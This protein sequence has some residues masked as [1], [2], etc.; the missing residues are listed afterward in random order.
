MASETTR[1][2]GA[3]RVL[4]VGGATSERLTTVV[5]VYQVGSMSSVAR[6]TRATRRRVTIAPLYDR[7]HGFG[8]G[9]ESRTPSGATRILGCQPIATTTTQNPPSQ[10]IVLDVCDGICPSDPSSTTG[11]RMSRLLQLVI[12]W[13]ERVKLDT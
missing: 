6:W 5:V 9:R 3:G 7:A 1:P 4:G 12:E 10:T 8:G 2:A 13:R 11:T